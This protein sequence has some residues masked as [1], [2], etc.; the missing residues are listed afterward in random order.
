MTLGRR[1]FIT[2]LG[3]AAAA[4]PLVA[5]A[6][7]SGPMRRIGVLMAGAESDDQGQLRIAA[8]RLG[9]ANL[10]W[11]EGRNARIDHRWG[12]DNVDRERAF[13]AELVGLRPDVLF[14]GGTPQAAALQQA[15]RSIPI[16]F[17]TVA[18][19][20]GAGFVA[21]LARPGGN[22]TGWMSVEPP[23][24][25]KWVQLLKEIAPGLRR[26]AYLFNPEV[27]SSYAGEFF[28][29]AEAAAVSLM[30]EM[31]AAA[32][33]NDTDI[34]E[35]F[36]V[37]AQEPNGGVIVNPDSFTRDHRQQIIAL[38]ARHRLPAIYSSRFHANDGGLICYGADQTDPF[39]RAASYVDRILRGEKPAN[40]PVQAL[41]KFEL[42]INL[43]TAKALGLDISHDLISIADEVIE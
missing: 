29:H 5:R 16:V 32:A 40:L 36:T 39:G 37:L 20:I 41:T 23:L 27:A 19:P 15:T 31:V 14:A 11:T 24:A 4:W 33:R 6:Q 10:G 12:T 8:F 21:S 38:A 7:Q 17:T 34:E 25:G 30:M 9:L 43:K 1:D 13:A 2:L 3:G 22:L 18:D 26:A 42:I 35:A 28:R